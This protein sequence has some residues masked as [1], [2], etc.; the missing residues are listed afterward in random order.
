MVGG[1][2]YGAE[3]GQVLLAALRLIEI[4]LIGR[5]GLLDRGV[6]LVEQRV[7]LRRTAH[8]AEQRADRREDRRHDRDATGKRIAGMRGML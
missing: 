8:V 4:P 6:V 1:R 5:F 3:L 7:V 2:Q